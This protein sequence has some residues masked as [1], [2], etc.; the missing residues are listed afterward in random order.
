MSTPDSRLPELIS[1]AR[2]S[3]SER[4]RA[5]LREL[6]ESFFGASG[7]GEV[8]TEAYGVI[9]AEVAQDM[10]AAVR[11][12][13]AER[14]GPAP[15]AP[16]GLVR[17]LAD[18]PEAAVA[19][20]VLRAS[21][22][23]TDEDLLRVVRKHGQDH[24][25]AVS[26]RPQVSEAVSD[27][28]VARGDDE[29]LG[30]LLRNDGARLS[31]QASEA[32]VERAKLNPAL[33]EATV[34]RASLPP[35]LL[36][37]MYFVVETRLRQSILEQNA[38][39][40]PALLE[41]A[42]RHGRAQVAT[43]DGV[44]P[45]DYAETLAK[46][47]QLQAANQLTPSVLAGFLRNNSKTAFLI[48]LAQLADLDFHTARHIVERRELDALAVVCRAADLDRALFL[49]YALVLLND[50]GDA[51]GKAKS[52]AEMYAALGRD[53]ALRTIRFWR[54]RREAVAA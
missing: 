17:T 25:R 18:D 44:L 38:K 47:E 52:Y 2:E 27:V 21:P 29:T 53:T 28:I 32:A 20:A 5:V 12:E 4:R 51:M 36:N 10:E 24:L 49:T 35:D 41:S 43:Q 40:D 33:H 11:A 37:D 45:E 48:A 22:L 46:V 7:H 15:H 9:L 26:A 34:N 42:L 50:D 1:L 30:T 19:T 16:R 14:F 3:S 13:L 6:T 8:E 54:L 39:M 31:R 23:L